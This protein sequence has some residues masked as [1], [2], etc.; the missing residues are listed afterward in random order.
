MLAKIKETSKNK[1]LMIVAAIITLI[2]LLAGVKA[3]RAGYHDFSVKISNWGRFVEV[4]GSTE[5][6]AVCYSRPKYDG[7]EFEGWRCTNNET[8]EEFIIEWSKIRIKN[9]GTNDVEVD[10]EK[11]PNAGYGWNQWAEKI[12]ENGKSVR[13]NAWYDNMF[14][15]SAD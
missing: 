10:W 5:N 3:V 1:T 7:H 13:L 14:Y 11:N 9:V 2:L 12:L 8:D 15:L 6:A 4:N